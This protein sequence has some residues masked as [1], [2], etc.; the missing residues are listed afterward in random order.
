MHAVC[1]I[2]LWVQCHNIHTLLQNVFVYTYT[3]SYIYIHI[4]QTI[5]YIL[6]GQNKNWLAQCHDNVT[7]WY[8]RSWCWRPG[9]P[10]GQYYK[11]VIGVHWHQSVTVMSQCQMLSGRTNITYLYAIYTQ[12]HSICYIYLDIHR[13]KPMYIISD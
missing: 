2:K 6:L 11:A 5:L 8:I 4:I 9:L 10:A 7:E 3:L 12:Q 13:N 1:N